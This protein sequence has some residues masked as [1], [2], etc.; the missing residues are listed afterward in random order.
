MYFRERAALHISS[1]AFL[2]ECY[3]ERLLG[4]NREMWDEGG[5]IGC[6]WAVER[7]LFNVPSVHIHY[8][9]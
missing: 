7:L 4:Q 6:E 5:L 8:T 3:S 1:A 2:F 9:P